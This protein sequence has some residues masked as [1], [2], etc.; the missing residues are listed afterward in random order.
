[1]NTDFCKRSKNN[2]FVFTPNKEKVQT[3]I[4]TIE[5]PGY[6]LAM[7]EFVSQHEKVMSDIKAVV[8]DG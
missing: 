1:M 8:N 4:F 5:A 6:S 2:K 7:T 3:V